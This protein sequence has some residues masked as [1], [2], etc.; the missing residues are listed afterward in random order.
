[1]PLTASAPEGN[2]VK[3][4]KG[5]HAA[6]CYS[7]IDLG[8]QTGEYEGQYYERHQVFISFELEETH[9]FDGVMKP[10]A[11]SEFYTLSLHEKAK[12]R[13]MLEGW[14]SKSF[15]SDELK[16]FDLKNILGK[17]C[18][19]NIIHKNDKAK[20]AAV[21]PADQR[22]KNLKRYNDLQYYSIEEEME[23]PSNVPDG[24][25]KIIYKSKEFNPDDYVDMRQDEP[26]FHG[27]DE[28]I[29]F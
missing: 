4:P 29:P 21:M 6:I 27:D 13:E 16:G 10:I 9:E 14:R 3:A 28:D 7:L 20:I 22:A 11:I 8:T 15:T 23:I 1:M 5:V 19:I 12:L 17:P 25:K 2:F 26:P 18:L 24:I